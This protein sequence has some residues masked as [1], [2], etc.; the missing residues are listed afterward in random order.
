[1]LAFYLRWTCCIRT[2]ANLLKYI[3]QRAHIHA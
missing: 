3:P 1:M 2:V